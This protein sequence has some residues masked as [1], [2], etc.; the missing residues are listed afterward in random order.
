MQA[1]HMRSN[2]DEVWTGFQQ[3]VDS[4][5]LE[6]TVASFFIFGY[7]LVHLLKPLRGKSKTVSPFIKLIKQIRA[8]YPAGNYDAVLDTWRKQI[9]GGNWAECCPLDVLR[10]VMHCLLVECDKDLT[11]V[12]ELAEYVCSFPD[13]YRAMPTDPDDPPPKRKKVPQD[14]DD[15]KSMILTRML[16]VTLTKSSKPIG[17]I[18]STLQAVMDAR[19]EEETFESLLTGYT[20]AADS[21][22]V[23]D[24]LSQ[25]RAQFNVVSPKAYGIVAMGFLKQQKFDT[26][27]KYL[28]EMCDVGCHLSNG[29]VAELFRSGSIAGRLDE[30]LELALT[31]HAKGCANLN[32]E[33]IYV[34]M[35]DGLRR[36]DVDACEKAA[37]L[38]RDLNVTMLY[39]TFD[40]LIKAHIICGTVKAFQYF[41]EMKELYALSCSSCVSMIT[42][43]Y[44][45][46]F[47]KFAEMVFEERRSLGLANLQMYSALIKVYAGVK[48]YEAV[49]DLYPMMLDDGIT[50]DAPMRGCLMSYASKAKRQDLVDELYNESSVPADEMYY[51]SILRT[52]RQDRDVTR[53]LKLKSEMMEK[54]LMDKG[55]WQTLLDVCAVAG[56]MDC[57]L[58]IFNEMKA[59]GFADELAYNR[60]VK[61]YCNADQ[62]PLAEKIIRTMEEDGF[63]PSS[64]T[65]N[66]LLTKHQGDGDFRKAWGVIRTMQAKGL[67]ED[68]FTVLTLVKAMKTCKD[69]VFVR[70]VLEL[71]DTTKVDLLRDDIY[72]NTVLDAVMRTKDMRRLS[73]LVDRTL[74]TKFIPSLATMNMMIKAYSSL[75]R[76][77]EATALWREMTEV[78]AVEPNMI[79]LGCITDALVVND[80]LDEAVTLVDEWKG[81][82]PLNTIIY[83][84]LIK[85]YAI[86][87]DAK[88]AL[89]VLD[90]MSAEGHAPNLVTIN[91]VID[92][93]CRAGALDECVK[94][95]NSLP[96]LGMDADRITYST[97]IKG[98]A[99]DG[100]LDGA[101]TFLRRMEAAGFRSDYTIFNV[102]IEAAAMRTRFDVADSCFEQMLKEGIAPSSYTLMILIKRHGREGNV[103]KAGELL[104]TLPAR[105]GFKVSANVYS[106]YITVCVQQN[107]LHLAL[108][109]YEKMKAE[110]PTPDAV[111]YDKL[112]NGCTR[113]G[114]TEVACKLV[115]DAYGINGPFGAGQR[116]HSGAPTPGGRASPAGL[117]H[118]VLERL[119]EQ[120][121]QRG[122]SESHA[123]PLVQKLRAAHVPVPQGLVTATLR[124]AVREVDDK[125]SAASKVSTAP[126]RKRPQ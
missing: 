34:M 35:E 58:R 22:M 102:L 115:L 25:I 41:D 36:K 45:S 95:F 31:L 69:E 114:Q 123:I 39:G 14:G 37:E 26:A 63:T 7:I 71:L 28:N 29:L 124:G 64:V 119:V 78:R 67:E 122:L 4:M 105:Y 126:W 111:T 94:V 110:G 65:Y 49:C 18:Y 121:T 20:N 33:S 60:L 19:P 6:F 85:G 86:R 92:A 80:R 42:H 68:W 12:Q 103:A 27:L 72:Y 118:G 89:R 93:C 15:S 77:D 98:F 74:K 125:V 24:V 97:V 66:F 8:D 5:Y 17:E 116:G 99:R 40:C 23:D 51:V 53:A 30:A 16:Q 56:D 10:M 96:S 50:P 54:G 90:R 100:D 76:I 3:V 84:T 75:K 57:T 112:I 62:L 46:K 38:A 70:N 61:G 2:Q 52:C 109:V 73:V 11:P 120:L 9:V 55:A 108:K 1:K 59:E 32:A 48:R 113:S 21:A 106:A 107:Q 87:K 82:V 81:R 101:A 44:D 83:S 13:P 117:D 47:V 91:T 104:E 88:G 79:S 43:C